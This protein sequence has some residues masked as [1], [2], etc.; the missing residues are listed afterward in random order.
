MH[1]KLVIFN[2]NYL[3]SE[4]FESAHIELFFQIWDTTFG[5]EHVNS[6]EVQSFYGLGFWR[7]CFSGRNLAKDVEDQTYLLIFFS[8]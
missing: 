1:F 4:L 7:F 8:M 3:P 6:L 5:P 2:W